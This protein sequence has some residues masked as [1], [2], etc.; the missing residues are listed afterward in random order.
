MSQHE[1]NNKRKKKKTYPNLEKATD[2]C[3]RQSESKMRN[4]AN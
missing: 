3:N 2:A 1:K 4:D